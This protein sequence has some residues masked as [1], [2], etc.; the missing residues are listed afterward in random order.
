MEVAQGIDSFL[1]LS[2]F[3]LLKSYKVAMSFL[4][5]AEKETEDQLRFHY[6]LGEK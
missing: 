4:I 5:V 6:C 1:R 2:Y 3:I